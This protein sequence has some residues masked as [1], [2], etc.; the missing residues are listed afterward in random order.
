MGEWQAMSAHRLRDV[1]L[2]AA[3]Q[4]GIP[5]RA[6]QPISRTRNGMMV[7]TRPRGIWLNEEPRQKGCR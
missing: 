7:W 5:L 6:V 4:T 3:V 1:P 2:G